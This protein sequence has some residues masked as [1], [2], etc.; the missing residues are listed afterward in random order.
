VVLFEVR[1]PEMSQGQCYC[2]VCRQCCLTGPTACFPVYLLK[3][4]KFDRSEKT[5]IQKLR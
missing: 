1:D 5:K 2:A 3:R 4:K